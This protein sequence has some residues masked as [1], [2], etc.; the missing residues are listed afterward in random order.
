MKK[1]IIIFTLGLFILNNGLYA[2]TCNGKRTIKKAIKDYELVVVGSVMSKE[3]VT[4]IDSVLIKSSQM[5]D[6]DFSGYPYELII[7][8]YKLIVLTQYKGLTTFDTIEIYTG[9]G[10]GDCGISF[11]IGKEYIIY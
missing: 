9:L 8:K 6:V 10:K 3:L 7:A 1:I 11:E 2:C 4:L 5:D